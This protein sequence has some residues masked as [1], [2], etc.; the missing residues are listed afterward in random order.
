MGPYDGICFNTGNQQYWMK[1]PD[2]ISLIPNDA[3]FTYLSSQ[4]PQETRIYGQLRLTG[5]PID[6]KE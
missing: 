6:G 2:E 1:S 5:T 4:G 3:L